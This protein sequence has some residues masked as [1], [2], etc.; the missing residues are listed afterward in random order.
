MPL[1]TVGAFQDHGEVEAK[2]EQDIDGARAL[3]EKLEA[4]GIDYSDVTE[5]L[6]REGVEK[7]AASFKELLDGVA[8]K[9][10]A[11]VPA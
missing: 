6:E 3:L 4:A 2:L 9:R 1:E 8:K 10:D 5:T 7:F 11:L